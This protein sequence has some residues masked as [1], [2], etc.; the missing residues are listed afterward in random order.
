MRPT[1]IIAFL[2]LS[3]QSIGQKWH[4]NKVTDKG[5][6][7]YEY[8]FQFENLEDTSSYS[9]SKRIYNPNTR[10]ILLDN[11]GESIP[12]AEIKLENLTTKKVL[13]L[14]S[15]EF[16]KTEPRLENGK[17]K[18]EVR[19]MNHD[20]YS[21]TFEIDQGEQVDI[22]IKLGRSPELEVYQINSKEEL[23]ETKVLEIIECV[24][25]NRNGFQK[26]CSHPAAYQVFLHI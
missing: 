10:F 18:M 23:S 3:F 7:R 24:R 8:W 19:A 11:Q 6:V 4:L 13:N 26:T 1:L 14:V 12:F 21:L 5:T 22:T 20:F 25:A 9:L 2:L 16:E 15:S 17:Y